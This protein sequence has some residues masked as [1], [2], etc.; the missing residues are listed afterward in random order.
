MRIAFFDVDTQ[1]DFANPAGALYVKGSE[2]LEGNFRLLIGFA[3][4]NGIPI[5]GSVDTHFGDE[6]HREREKDELR[7]WGGPFPDHCIKGTW[8][9]QKIAATRPVNPTFVPDNEAPTKE[10]VNELSR[11][12]EVYFEKIIY[13]CFDN[14]LA[15]PVLNAFDRF[16]VFGLATDYCVRATALGLREMGKEVIVVS[17]AIAPVDPAGG[18]RAIEEMRNAGVTFKTTG[19]VLAELGGMA[20]GGKGR[21]KLGKKKR[22]GMKKGRKKGKRR[23]R[24][25]GG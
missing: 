10:R 15:R 1:E 21:K 2:G 14:P 17:D 18:R 8:G 19:E 13:S 11:K 4:K 6:A 25:L 16:V 20:K 12:T 7:K 22:G 9:H 23:K 24:S 5:F 3:R